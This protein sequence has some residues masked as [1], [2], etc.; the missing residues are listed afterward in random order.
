MY[1]ILNLNNLLKSDTEQP[2]HKIPENLSVSSQK[3]LQPMAVKP[4]KGIEM[5]DENNK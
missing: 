5:N 4:W 3:P 2:A 1:F